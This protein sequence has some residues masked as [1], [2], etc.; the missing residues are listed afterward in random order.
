MLV[1]TFYFW[2]R[3]DQPTYPSP[4]VSPGYDQGRMTPPK[5]SYPHTRACFGPGGQLVKVLPN[6]PA[7]GQPAL[8]EVQDVQS[9]LQACPEAEELHRFPG[10]LTRYVGRSLYIPAIHSDFI[11]IIQIFFSWN[12]V[13]IKIFLPE[14]GRDFYIKVLF[15]CQIL[16]LFCIFRFCVRSKWQ[17]CI[18]YETQILGTQVLLL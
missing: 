5:Y 8:V 7:D 15:W 13:K 2:S 17:V 12:L 18:I 9:L 14:F 1:L 10:P 11:W 16:I 4:S 3:A 6:R